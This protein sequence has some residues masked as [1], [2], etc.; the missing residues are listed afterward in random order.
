MG[1][2]VAVIRKGVLQQVDTP[3]YLYDHPNNLFVAG[4][5]GSPA[6][7]M[8]EATFA[9]SNGSAFVE[10]G[11]TRLAVPTTRS[12]RTPGPRGASMARQV[13]VGL[14][15]GGH[16][17]RRLVYRRAPDRRS[18][19]RWRSARPS[20][21]MSSCTSSCRPPTVM[22]DDVKELAVDVG[23]EALEAVELGAR[24]GQ[25]KFVA[26]LNPRTG[27]A[28]GEPIELVVDA[29]PPPFLRSRLRAG[30]LRGRAELSATR[31]SRVLIPQRVPL[32]RRDVRLPGRR[33][34]PRGRARHVDLGHVLPQ[35]GRDPRWDTG[36]VACDQYHRF[37]DDVALMSE[38]GIGAYRFSVSWPRIQPEGRGPAEQRGLDHYRRLVDALRR[39]GITPVPTLFH[40][41]LPQALEDAGGGRPGA[42]P[43]R[44]ADYAAIVGEALGDVVPCGSR[45]T[46]RWWPPGSATA[47]GVHAPGRRDEACGTRRDPS[48]APGPWPRGRGA[49][50]RGDGTGRASRSTSTRASRPATRPTTSGRPISPTSSINRLYLDPIFGRGYPRRT[51]EH[52]APRSTWVPPRRGPG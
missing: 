2:R 44:F 20:G 26:R 39:H 48:P 12:S 10:F 27:A 16:G 50:V 4:F 32:G 30:D 38:L 51:L 11:G 34:G 13:I 14:R 47:N 31:A 40:W 28:K 49:P 25:S 23:Q 29:R 24:S 5:I 46:N 7:N 41:D 15:P 36:D 9:R 42:P 19:P 37:E 33:R 3:Q 8:V 17:G 6:M 22:T 52:D 1:D 45:S 18:D 21:P 35:A 43:T